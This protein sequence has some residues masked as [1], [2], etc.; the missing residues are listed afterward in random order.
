MGHEFDVTRLTG[1][2]FK[3][4][5][6]TSARTTPDVDPRECGQCTLGG[7]E[8][9]RRVREVAYSA[10]SG[11]SQLRQGGTRGPLSHSGGRARAGRCPLLYLKVQR[12]T[13]Q[14]GEK[15]SVLTVRVAGHHLGLSAAGPGARQG[16]CG[17]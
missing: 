7:R 4:P 9:G 3:Q 17:G 6:R 2:S 11:S 5:K 16:G 1:T 14:Y 8:P 15:A 12:R 13:S 10:C